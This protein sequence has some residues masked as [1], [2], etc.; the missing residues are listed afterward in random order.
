MTGRARALAT[1]GVLALLL[2]VFAGTRSIDYIALGPG[3]IFDTLGST[4]GTPLIRIDPGPVTFPAGGHLY[5]T[6]VSEGGRL[7]VPTLVVNW[8]RSDRAVLPR[9]LIIPKGQTSQQVEQQNRQQMQDSQES[10]INVALDYLGKNVVT[11]ADVPKGSPSAGLLAPKDVILAINGT[12]VGG[13]IALRRILETLT[14][15]AAV[16]V[17]ARAPGEAP[18]DVKITTT[19]MTDQATGKP[20]AFVGVSVS[21]AEAPDGPKIH[22]DLPNVGGPSAGLMFTLGILDLLQPGDLTGGL[23]IAG[24]GEIADDGRI[25]PIG[26]IQEKLLGARNPPAGVG[27]PAT[28]FLTPAANCAEAKPVVPP[29]LRLVKVT[30]VDDAL[31]ALATLRAGGNPP[32]C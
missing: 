8:L 13:E 26:G 4:G 7:T 28:V 10:A 25:G 18:R 6:T 11:V 2:A 24:T 3:P 21:E 29:G 12:A 20:R 32:T 9:S 15:G 19:A 1:S 30:T 23:S 5:V 27:P 31:S 22:I 16:T 14:P 17:R